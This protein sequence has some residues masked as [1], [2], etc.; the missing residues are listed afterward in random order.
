MKKYFLSLFT[1]FFS[2]ISLSENTFPRMNIGNAHYYFINE[3]VPVFDSSLNKINIYYVKNDKD[4]VLNNIVQ[5][6]RLGRISSFMFLNGRNISRKSEIKYFENTD[7]V[8]SDIT[9]DYTTKD[10]KV[11]TYVNSYEYDLNGKKIFQYSYDIDT[12]D[13][14]TEKFIYKDGLL[15][16]KY[17]KTTTN[18]KFYLSTVFSYDKEKRLSK[19]KILYQDFHILSTILKYKYDTNEVKEYREKQ[20]GKVLLNSKVYK[21][22]L[23]V[24][25]KDFSEKHYETFKGTSGSITLGTESYEVTYFYDNKKLVEV[26]VK[27][28]D[29]SID[30]FRLYYILK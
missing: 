1:F 24:K 20:D 2:L 15:S 12:T 28:S 23:L 16:K 13:I 21:D 27:R 4:S 22:G 25:Y 5:Y 7:V 3:L 10:I 19:T 11:W 8:L 9:T 14:K 29:K 17:T 30:K 26:Q 6:D 18:P